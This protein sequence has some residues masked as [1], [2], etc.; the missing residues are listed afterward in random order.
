MHSHACS[1]LDAILSN[2]KGLVEKIDLIIE[3]NC[4]KK[5]EENRR[6]LAPMIDNAVLLNR[7]GLEFSAF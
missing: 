5:V 6:R 1:F 2:I 4:K 3:R 7:F